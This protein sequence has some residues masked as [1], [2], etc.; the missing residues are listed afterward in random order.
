[1]SKQFTFPCGPILQGATPIDLTG[2]A[3]DYP[4][5]G[6]YT[7]ETTQ[8]FIYGTRY[9]TY[10][11]AVYKYSKSS[12]ACYTGELN[13]FQHAIDSVG[14]D[15]VVL[16]NTS[17][18]GATEIVMTAALAQAKDTLAGGWIEF[19]TAN[20]DAAGNET[21]M[22]RRIIGNTACG[23]GATTVVT[24]NG[25]L[26]AALTA[27]TGYA[28]C[29]PNPYS[30]VA[31]DTAATNSACGLAATYIAATGYNHWEQTWGLAFCTD[32]AATLGKTDNQRQLV[33]AQNGGVSPHA[34][35]TASVTAQQH[36][37]FIVDDNA[38]ANGM[39]MI[40]LQIDI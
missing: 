12:G 16:P 37:G 40:M 4:Y 11:G 14:I 18:I 33:L 19:K 9:I 8:R 26:T 20:T 29:M 27:A 36:I 17:A 31:Y 25:P 15:Y 5:L 23:A 2:T 24:L 30:S 32:V 22:Q 7:T 1:M 6:I 34:Y 28:F 13:K 21:G 10:D 3:V 38:T 35:A 39:S